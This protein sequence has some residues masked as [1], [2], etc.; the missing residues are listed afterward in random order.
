MDIKTWYENSDTVVV[1]I[2]GAEVALSRQ[3]AESLFVCLGHTLQDLDMVEQ[4]AY[5]NHSEEEQPDV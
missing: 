4:A 5:T 2:D 3:E 1:N